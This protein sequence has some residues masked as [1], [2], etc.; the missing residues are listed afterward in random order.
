LRNL[1]LLLELKEELL[2]TDAQKLVDRRKEERQKAVK[3]VESGRMKNLEQIFYVELEPEERIDPLF[4]LHL[5]SEA[6]IFVA[7]RP[8]DGKPDKWEARIRLGYAGMEKIRLNELGINSFDSG[9]MGR[10]DA[11][12]NRRA[13]EGTEKSLDEYILELNEK[14]KLFLE[15]T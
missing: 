5:I 7:F 10:F 9:W 15:P 4:F 13:G 12:S 14:R 11:G 2:E 8:F 3:I 6:E 1:Q